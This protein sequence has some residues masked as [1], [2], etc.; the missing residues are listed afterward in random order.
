MEH[1]HLKLHPLV[2]TNKTLS[3]REFLTKIKNNAILDLFKQ[4]N[5]NFKNLGAWIPGSVLVSGWQAL[6]EGEEEGEEEEDGEEDGEEEEEDGEESVEGEEEGGREERRP[7][8]VGRGLRGLLPSV[9]IVLSP[10]LPSSPSS[11]ASSVLPS[12]ST[13]RRKSS[14]APSSEGGREGGL[15]Q[16]PTSPLAGSSSTI[17]SSAPCPLPPPLAVAGA[18]AGAGGVD[19]E[20]PA[21]LLFGGIGGGGGGG[22][23][24]G[25]GGKEGGKAGGKKSPT[26]EDRKKMLFGGGGGEGGGGGGGGKGGGG[27]LLGR[28]MGGGKS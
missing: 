2:Y 14:T 8:S 26:A 22:G 15:M 18:G 21:T 13:P 28:F 12:F 7:V 24:G 20:R 1:L 10:S 17:S 25:E 19:R 3:A 4:V 9:P 6:E 11:F 23:G 27:G 5:R 16:A